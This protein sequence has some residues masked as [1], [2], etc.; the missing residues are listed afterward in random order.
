MYYKI[1]LSPFEIIGN[2]YLCYSFSKG[3]YLTNYFKATSFTKVQIEN[4]YK[5][6]QFLYNK[7]YR[8]VEVDDKELILKYISCN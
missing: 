6:K 3:F 1:E 7:E 4:D 8:I 5:L 2:N